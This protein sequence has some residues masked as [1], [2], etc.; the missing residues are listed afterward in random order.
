MNAFVGSGGAA[1]SSN[2]LDWETPQALF[3]SL[4]EIH[5]FTLD[6]A[7]NGQNAKC[8]KYF[9]VAD[10]GLN[11]DWGGETVFLNPPYGRELPKWVSKSAHEALK[12]DT[13]VV[14]LIPARTDTRWFHR[15]LYHRAKLTFLKG[16]VH[17]EIHGK[18][19]Q[20]AP[21]PSMIAE[22]GQKDIG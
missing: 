20:S 2:R 17:F 4:D 16:R 19:L 18:P 1:F 7:S 10:N 9:T 15:Y 3:D 6:P 22:L 5:H 21:F 14:L 12:P 13:L 11:Q 8:A